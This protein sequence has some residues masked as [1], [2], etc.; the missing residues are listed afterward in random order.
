MALQLAVDAR[1]AIEDTRG[2]G[3]YAR[4]ILRRLIARDD[5]ALV[6]LASGPFAFRHRRAYVAALGS[7]R[8]ELRPNPGSADVVWHP[9]NGTFFRS[10]RPTV[11]T[12]HDA[13]PFR[14]PSADPAKRARDQEPFLLSART[15]T[16]IVAV[17]N[18]GKHEIH[19]V[20]GVPEG[21]IEVIHHGVEPTFSPGPARPLPEGLTEGKYVLFVGDPIG[22]PRKNFDMLYAAFRTAWPNDGPSLVVV[23]PRAPDLPN[24]R[25]AGNLGDDLRDRANDRLRALYRGAIALAMASYHE[26]FGMPA[27]EAMACG[28][29]VVASQA[30]CLPEIAGN[31]ALFAPPDDPDAWASALLRVRDDA[32]LR[33]RLQ[34]AGIERATHFDWDTS[35]RR[36]FELFRSVA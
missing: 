15:A 30:S 11:V 6:L 33:E 25:H 16:R 8:F 9:A 12:L 3:R 29:P 1:V 14:Y 31:A 34:R 32:A 22:E 5:V 18:F 20:F 7:D 2:I 36:H 26:T 27:I 10:N 19:E 24:V 35:A 23:G 28:T 13:V 17:S 4:A 21:R